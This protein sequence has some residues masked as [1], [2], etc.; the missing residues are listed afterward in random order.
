MPLNDSYGVF[1]EAFPVFTRQHMQK[2]YFS[3][4]YGEHA[5]AHNEPGENMEDVLEMGKKDGKYMRFRPSRAPLFSR[6]F[7]TYSAHYD[8]KP[9]G[10]N[11]ANKMLAE[12]F[13]PVRNTGSHAKLDSRSTASDAF[14]KFNRKQSQL[15]KPPAQGPNRKDRTKMPGSA[16]D[17]LLVTKSTSH[18][19]HREPFTMPYNSQVKPLDNIQINPKAHG[20]YVSRYNVDYKASTLGPR[21]RPMAMAPDPGFPNLERQI[22][23]QAWSM[24]RCNFLGPGR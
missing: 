10:D 9:L 4:S 2:L 5:G 23:D 3:T 16:S 15:A 18:E 8:E 11:V 24:R 7:C 22:S 19:Q 6:E 13:R 14:I 1:P 20:N 17:S 12:S 21:Q